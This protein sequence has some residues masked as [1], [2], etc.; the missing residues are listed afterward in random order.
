MNKKLIT[1]LYR[2]RIDA[3]Y[4]DT[5]D[6]SIKLKGFILTLSNKKTIYIIKLDK[7][8]VKNHL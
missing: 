8:K 1:Y 5:M 2:Y 3:Y 7:F 6:I 4:N